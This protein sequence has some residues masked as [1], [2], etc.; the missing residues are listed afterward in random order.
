[1]HRLVNRRITEWVDT[2]VRMYSCV[3]VSSIFTGVIVTAHRF[4]RERQ[5]E[6]SITVTATDWAEEPLIGIC[7]LTIQ[8]LDQNDN[9]PKFENLRYECKC[10]LKM[11]QVDTAHRHDTDLKTTFLFEKEEEITFVP[12]LNELHLCENIGNKQ[13]VD[14]LNHFCIITL[15]DL[16]QPFALSLTCLRS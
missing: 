16:Q 6:Y 11:V 14:T 9:S 4:D 12:L 8:I 15:H 2:Y 3:H 10:W 13:R 7:Q 1:M 5:R